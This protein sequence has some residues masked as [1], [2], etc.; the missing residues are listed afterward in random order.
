MYRHTDFPTSGSTA[1]T[2]AAPVT[3]AGGGAVPRSRLV[4]LPVHRSIFAVDIERS[5]HCSNPVKAELRGQLYALLREALSGA[6]I[7]PDDCDPL[8][9]RGDGVLVLIHPVDHVPKL[10]LFTRLVPRLHELVLGHNDGIPEAERSVRGLRLRAVLHAGEVHNDGNGPFGES[11]DVAF[12]LLDAR[13]VKACLRCTGGP[14]VLVVSDY[15]HAEIVR[16]CYAGIEPEVFTPMITAV[17]QR[18]RRGWL[19]LL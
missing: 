9:D 19:R 8:V 13:P 10:L 15:L 18:R 5:T 4:S 3:H 16:H 6:G 1:L 14:V 2:A 7:E 17:G 11:L 12:R